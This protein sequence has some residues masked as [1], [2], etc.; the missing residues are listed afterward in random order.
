VRNDTPGRRAWR[1][2]ADVTVRFGALGAP[3]AVQ[4][5]VFFLQTACAGGFFPATSMKRTLEPDP[6][7]RTVSRCAPMGAHG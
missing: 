4:A 3:Q 1:A 7:I 6:R 2:P 5:T